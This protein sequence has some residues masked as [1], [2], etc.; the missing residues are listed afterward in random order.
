MIDSSRNKSML[1]ILIGITAAIVAFFVGKKVVKE[2]RKKKA[3][4]EY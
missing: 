3:Q 1:K 2:V 4:E